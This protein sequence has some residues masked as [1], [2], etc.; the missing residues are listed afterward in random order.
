MT[1]INRDICMFIYEINKHYK[2]INPP[3]IKFNKIPFR[4]SEEF[5][6][7][8]KHIFNVNNNDY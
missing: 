6:G 3:Q 5:Y 1:L 7:N 4:I 2:K 8:L